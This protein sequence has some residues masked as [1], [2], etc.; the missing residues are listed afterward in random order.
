[1]P[2]GLRS[3]VQRRTLLFLWMTGCE[4][5]AEAHPHVVAFKAAHPEIVVR[6]VDLAIE[7]WPEDEM[8]GPDAVPSYADLI[9]GGAPRTVE[10]RGLTKEEIESWFF[11][12]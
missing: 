6:E 4:A 12:R 2:F 7:D 3:G 9:P 8:I 11:Q 10:G 1:M 5:C